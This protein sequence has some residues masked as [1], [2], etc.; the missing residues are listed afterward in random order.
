MNHGDG[1]KSLFVQFDVVFKDNKMTNLFKI[2]REFYL[3]CS[4]KEH[5]LLRFNFS[6]N[7]FFNGLC[8]GLSIVQV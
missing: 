2:E 5:R 6:E 8:L 7:I 1:I 4:L 3:K